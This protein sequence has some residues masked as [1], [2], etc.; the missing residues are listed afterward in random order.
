MPTVRKHQAMVV[1]GRDQC[2]QAASTRPASRADTANAK[3][4]TKPT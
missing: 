4:T 1:Q 3:A 2:A